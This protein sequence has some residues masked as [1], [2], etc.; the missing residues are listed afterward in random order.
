MN[1]DFVP[2]VDDQK[3]IYLELL[4]RR[5]LWNYCCRK[6]ELNFTGRD[7]WLVPRMICYIYIF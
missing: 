5:V 3:E 7:Y 6:E 2:V 4:Q 1:R